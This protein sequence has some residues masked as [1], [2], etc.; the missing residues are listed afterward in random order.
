MAESDALVQDAVD[1]AKPAP[2]EGP[3]VTCHMQPV[4]LYDMQP[5]LLCPF[6]VT[7]HMQP[8]ALYDMQPVLLCPFCTSASPFSCPNH[9]HA[10]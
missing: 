3:C 5:V 10:P 2:L 4:A 9:L 6:C 7:C 1:R 8:V